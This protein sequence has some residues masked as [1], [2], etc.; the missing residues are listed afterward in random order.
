MIRTGLWGIV[1][2]DYSLFATAGKGLELRVRLR[3]WGL[4]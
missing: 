4:G 1:F 3:A 2:Y